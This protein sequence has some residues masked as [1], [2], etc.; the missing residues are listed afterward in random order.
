M[1]KKKSQTK[2]VM[3]RSFCIDRN[4]QDA[5]EVKTLKKVMRYEKNKQFFK[6]DIFKAFFVKYWFFLVYI[7]AYRT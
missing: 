4:K 7:Y 1:L 6:N 2:I 3:N 5:I